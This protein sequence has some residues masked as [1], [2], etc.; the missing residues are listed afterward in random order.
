MKIV[1]AP[2]AFKES[3]SSAEVADHIEA[4][5]REVC[6]DWNYVKVPIADGGE[7]TVQALVAA[8]GGRIVKSRATGPVGEPVEAF[9]GISGDG[10][11]AVIEMAA[12]SGLALIRP[13]QRDPLRTT[14]FGVGELIRQALDQGARHLII[15]IGGSATND[16]GAGMMEALGARFLDVDGHPLARGGGALGALAHI[17]ISGI[18]PRLAECDIEVAR[19]VDN[20][21]VGPFGASAVFGPQKGAT[22]EV[23]QTLD[24]NLRHYAKRME[25]DLGVHVA[26]LPGGGAAGG[27]GAAMAGFLGANLRPGVEIVADVVGLETIL[28]DADLVIT[29]EGRIDSQSIRGKTPIGVAAMARRQGAPVIAISGSLGEGFGLIHDFGVDAVFSVLGQCCTIDEALSQAGT[30]VRTT[31]RNL[32]AALKIG[33]AMKVAPHASRAGFGEPLQA[34]HAQII[35]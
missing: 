11:T 17:D 23:A 25:I 6:P 26:D 8:T 32:A 35:Q 29:G 16:G 10:K 5:F 18:D 4:G 7:G 33:M 13:E 31:A 24:A 30:N 12:A 1:I 34:T 15:G 2:D 9:F 22:P 27:L 20:P 19:D 21:L 14:T 3:L 28:H